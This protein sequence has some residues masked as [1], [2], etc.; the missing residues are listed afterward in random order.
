M[1][2]LGVIVVP[3]A[4]V[5]VTAAV[6]KALRVP[7]GRS[8]QITAVDQ[9]P[10]AGPSDLRWV[11]GRRCVVGGAV[12]APGAKGVPV[13]VG[14]APAGADVL[15]ARVH[16]AAVVSE[17]RAVVESREPVLLDRGGG[18]YLEDDPPRASNTPA[19]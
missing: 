12:Q 9:R 5:V 18:R 4:V 7:R 11:R 3:I 1:T 17:I 19:N 13:E 14:L 10:V 2:D 16:L 6:V 8:G 15:V